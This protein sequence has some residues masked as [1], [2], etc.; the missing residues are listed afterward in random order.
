MRLISIVLTLAVI[1]TGV[2]LYM[3]STGDAGRP[4][5]GTG[6]QAVEQAEQAT[7]ALQQS[8]EQQQQRMQDLE[9]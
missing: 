4:A 8:L 6:R 1:G 7:Q 9:K 3:K 5:P 2:Y